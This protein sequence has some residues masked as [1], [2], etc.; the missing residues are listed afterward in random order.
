MGKRN[1]AAIV[2]TDVIVGK[3]GRVTNSGIADGQNQI[4]AF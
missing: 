2:A 3:T 1:A 4:V